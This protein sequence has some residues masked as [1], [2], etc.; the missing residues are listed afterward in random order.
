MGLTW[1]LEVEAI[2]RALAKDT[3]ELAADARMGD[4]QE[5]AKPKE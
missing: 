1:Y 5:R 2:L 3:R 4:I